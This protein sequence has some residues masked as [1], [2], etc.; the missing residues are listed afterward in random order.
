MVNQN[1]PDIQRLT[2][3][4]LVGQSLAY[5]S[6]GSFLVLSHYLKQYFFMNYLGHLFI[7][8]S[9]L[10]L[11]ACYK[12]KLARRFAIIDTMFSGALFIISILIVLITIIDEIV[13]SH[14]TQLNTISNTDPPILFIGITILVSLWVLIYMF[15]PRIGGRNRVNWRSFPAILFLFS[16][17]IIVT[18]MIFVWKNVEPTNISYTILGLGVLVYGI[19]LFLFTKNQL[20]ARFWEEI[21][22]RAPRIFFMGVL[23]FGLASLVSLII[24]SISPLCFLGP[25]LSFLAFTLALGS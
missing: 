25:A 16:M 3:L 19:S 11:I 4:N 23:V 21:W 5:L 7:S 13:F 9:L 20:G 24:H 18:G 10:V 17:L 22:L 2:R 8:I 12:F 15:L 14:N 1:E 6:A